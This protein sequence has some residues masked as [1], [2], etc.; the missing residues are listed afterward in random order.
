M[1]TDIGK[2]SD[3]EDFIENLKSE[4]K[5]HQNIADEYRII[6]AKIKDQI[7]RKAKLDNA[8]DIIKIAT[9]KRPPVPTFYCAKA[10]SIQRQS[11]CLEQCNICKVSFKIRNR[12]IKIEDE[13]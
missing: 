1:E 7:D 10:E 9:A 4:I 8:V 13:V 3:L 12:S 6:L 11:K 5:K 2:I